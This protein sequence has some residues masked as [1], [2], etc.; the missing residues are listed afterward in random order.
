MH[1]ACT[2]ARHHGRMRKIGMVAV[3][4]SFFARGVKDADPELASALAKEL[5]ALRTGMEY[6]PGS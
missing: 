4:E 1:K 2:G 5:S 6:G 3:A